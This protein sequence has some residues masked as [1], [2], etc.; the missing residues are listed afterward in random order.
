MMTYN[1]EE[2]EKFD[3]D[4][5]ETDGVN[6]EDD[7]DTSGKNSKL[8]DKDIA[9]EIDEF[10]KK[11]RFPGDIC[12]TLKMPDNYMKKARDKLNLALWN[13]Y[14]KYARTVTRTDRYGNEYEV[15][16]FGMFDILITLDSYVDPVK[17]SAVLD[18]DIKQKVAEERG[19]RISDDELDYVAKHPG[20]TRADKD[21]ADI[22]ECPECHGT[23]EVDGE[24]CS[25][26][27]GQG[28][29]ARVVDDVPAVEPDDEEIDLAQLDSMMLRTL[30]NG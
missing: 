29:V 4:P 18:N 21:S 10:L 27:L 11:P 19:I 2:E 30:N 15:P 8:G 16:G 1:T 26:C 23:G 24:E 28:K 25:L 13:A 20:T 6:R 22:V 7:I 5:Q 9:H 12:I 3:G 17:L 14:R